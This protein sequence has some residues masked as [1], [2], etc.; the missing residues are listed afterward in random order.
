MKP[1]WIKDGAHKKIVFA[2]QNIHDERDKEEM[3]LGFDR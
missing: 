2:G 1:N 3:G